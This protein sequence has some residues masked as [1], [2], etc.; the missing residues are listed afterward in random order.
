MILIGVVIFCNRISMFHYD[1]LYKHKNCVLAD[2]KNFN[3]LM[4]NLYEFLG[5]MLFCIMND[6]FSEGPLKNSTLV[7]GKSFDV[8]CVSKFSIIEMV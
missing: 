5:K 2:Q 1:K 8:A 3:R 6:L 4:A 7:R